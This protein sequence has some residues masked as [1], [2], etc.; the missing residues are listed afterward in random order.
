MVDMTAWLDSRLSCD[1]EPLSPPDPRLVRSSLVTD[2]VRFKGLD[3]W[4]RKTMAYY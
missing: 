2:L 3:L 4:Q 1:R